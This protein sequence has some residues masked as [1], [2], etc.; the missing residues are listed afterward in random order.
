[1]A[2]GRRSKQIVKLEAAKEDLEK[3]KWRSNSIAGA[4]RDEIQ[5]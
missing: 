4:A 1:M 2:S 5:V 3:K